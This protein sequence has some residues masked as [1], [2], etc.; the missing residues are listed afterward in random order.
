VKNKDVI[1]WILSIHATAVLQLLRRETFVQLFL[2][3]GSVLIKREKRKDLEFFLVKCG[4]R[5]LP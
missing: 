5:M 4:T 3:V 2:F 1:K